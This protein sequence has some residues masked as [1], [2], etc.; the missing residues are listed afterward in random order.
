MTERHGGTVQATGNV[1]GGARL[2]LKL[3][4][5]EKPDA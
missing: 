1:D 3:P 2:V 4:G 5:T